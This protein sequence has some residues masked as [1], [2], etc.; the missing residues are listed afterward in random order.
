M[1]IAGREFA[2]IVCLVWPWLIAPQFGTG[3]HRDQAGCCLPQQMI[4]QT[5]KR[6]HKQSMP[7][8]RRHTGREPGL[9]TALTAQQKPGEGGASEEEG[10][11]A[12]G[13]G[14]EGRS[15]VWGPINADIAGRLGGI[16]MR[17]HSGHAGE[18]AH[19]EGYQVG[20]HGRRGSK[21]GGRQA[22]RMVLGGRN[23]HIRQSCQPCCCGETDVKGRLQRKS[24]ALHVPHLSG[25][26]TRS[27]CEC[28]QL[29]WKCK[30]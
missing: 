21:V 1:H 2:C 22:C 15:P 17:N 29:W 5:G 24:V 3:Q 4:S 18:V 14:E 7:A 16:R 20:R 6:L 10:C 12:G 25:S 23:G 28:I 19:D 8:F 11:G 26:A 30:W 13:G 27:W 9:W